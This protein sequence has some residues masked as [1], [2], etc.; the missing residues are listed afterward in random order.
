MRTDKN[1]LS[2]DRAIERIA[3]RDKVISARFVKRESARAPYNRAAARIRRTGKENGAPKGPLADEGCRGQERRTRSGWTSKP[4]APRS[5]GTR[6]S[7]REARRKV[8]RHAGC[9]SRSSRLGTFRVGLVVSRRVGSPWFSRLVGRASSASPRPPPILGLAQSRRWH[10]PRNITP[11]AAFDRRSLPPP[12]PAFL[13][14]SHFQRGVESLL[15]FR[16]CP[17]RV[18]PVDSR[19]GLRELIDRN[20]T[21][22]MF[23]DLFRSSMLD[24]KNWREFLFPFFFFFFFS[25]RPNGT[26]VRRRIR[27][28]ESA[29]VKN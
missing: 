20:E 2:S 4:A 29:F 22:I 27:K 26:R 9:R 25:F 17:S 24:C 3:R 11:R 19:F 10:P 1:R 5:S 8:A 16:K 14:G 28:E 21:V 13:I 6:R 18:R 23:L 15:Y 7:R 12:S